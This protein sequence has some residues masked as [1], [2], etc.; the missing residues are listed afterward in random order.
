MPRLPSSTI[1]GSFGEAK[2]MGVK[3]GRVVLGAE[4]AHEQVGGQCPWM[5][6][7]S[8]FS[9]QTDS[10]SSDTPMAC[11]ENDSAT[12][13]RIIRTHVDIAVFVGRFA[14]KSKCRSRPAQARAK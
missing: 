1:G 4:H 11:A 14:Q 9:T 2:A 13:Q 3:D 6:S 10:I 7:L 5:S 8:H 12:A